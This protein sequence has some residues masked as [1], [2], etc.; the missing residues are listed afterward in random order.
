MRVPTAPAN[1]ILE[2]LDLPAPEGWP[3]E[4]VVSLLAGS[5]IVASLA[6]A[7][8]RDPRWRVL[9]GLI[10]ANLALQGAVGW[11]PT[12]GALYKLGVPLARECRR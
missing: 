11:C 9:T 1:P 3:L 12:S 4:R 7:R 2:R 10:G 8:A 6:L 5:L